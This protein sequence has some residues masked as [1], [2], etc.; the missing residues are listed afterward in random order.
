[1]GIFAEPKPDR[2]DEA[3]F[4]TWQSGARMAWMRGYEAVM[5]AKL[6]RVEAGFAWETRAQQD[7]RVT[8]RDDD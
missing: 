6:L 7:W 4:K 5:S 1:M 3:A 2:T 8:S